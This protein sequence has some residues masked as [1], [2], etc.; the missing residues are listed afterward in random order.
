MQV[1]VFTAALAG[2]GCH[3]TKM[4]SFGDFPDQRIKYAWVTRADESVVELREA[5]SINGKLRGFVNRELQ[6]FE[7]A[8]LKLIKIR[9]LAGG[10]TAALVVGGI[11]AAIGVAVLV[12]GTEDTFDPCVGVRP[13]CQTF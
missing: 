7:P 12:S 13:D 8:D 10:R 4:V 2:A 9:Q 3:V 11:A 6:E 1:V 5:E